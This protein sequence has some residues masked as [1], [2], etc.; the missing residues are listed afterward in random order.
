M[1]RAAAAGEWA[2]EE[3]GGRVDDASVAVWERPGSSLEAPCSLERGLVMGV[4]GG[5][6][7]RRAPG[8]GETVFFALPTGALFSSAMIVFFLLLVSLFALCFYCRTR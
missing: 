7:N 2:A 6:S 1:P 5:R 8:G 4:G 3:D